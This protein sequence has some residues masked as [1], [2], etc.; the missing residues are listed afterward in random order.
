MLA[1][2]QLSS[3]HADAVRE[4]REWKD[5]LQALDLSQSFISNHDVTN[6]ALGAA[7]FDDSLHRALSHQLDRA[8][9]ERV[10]SEP[11]ASHGRL[12]GVILAY[13]DGARQTLR[14]D[15]RDD[16]CLTIPRIVRVEGRK[17]ILYLVICHD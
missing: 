15:A 5:T 1:L 12:A 13:L 4:E 16:A 7:A 17:A 6:P 11:M 10:A 14:D 8:L 3:A 9:L 2:T